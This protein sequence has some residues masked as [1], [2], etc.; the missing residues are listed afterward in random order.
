MSDPQ[1]PDTAPPDP[2][3]NLAS[4]QPQPAADPGGRT[5]SPDTA[6]PDPRANVKPEELIKAGIG[7]VGM[8]RAGAPPDPHPGNAV[9]EPVNLDMLSSK[10]DGIAAQNADILAALKRGA[11]F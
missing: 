11:R 7:A 2:Q 5:Q 3:V 9:K 4:P 1:S 6:P 10:L 8:R